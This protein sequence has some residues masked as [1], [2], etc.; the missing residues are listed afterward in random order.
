MP[1]R[2]ERL[3]RLIDHAEPVTPEQHRKAVRIVRHPPKNMP[4]LA[5]LRWLGIA[6]VSEPTPEELRQDAADLRL[7]DRLMH[8]SIK[9]KL[10]EWC[11]W[12]SWAFISAS[13]IAL[14]FLFV[15]V[16]HA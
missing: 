15:L 8:G 10:R 12:N 13:G 16:F 6:L 5:W 3:M 7:H 2:L 11:V 9:D 1:S 4:F 14:M